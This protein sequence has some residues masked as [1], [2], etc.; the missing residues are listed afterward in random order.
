MELFI[1]NCRIFAMVCVALFVA[2]AF[3]GYTFE[4]LHAF[5]SFGVIVVSIVIYAFIM[6]IYDAIFPNKE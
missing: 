6:V 2:Q 5:I 4:I 1:A 3:S